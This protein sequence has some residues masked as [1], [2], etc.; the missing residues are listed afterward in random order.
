MSASTKAL[1]AS[2]DNSSPRSSRS[3]PGRLLAATLVAGLT[4]TGLA[5]TNAQSASAA[6][7]LLAQSVG[8]FLDGSAGGNPIQ[9]LVDLADARATS[10]GTQ[11]AQNPL[12]VT[13]LG[14]INL[15]L[16]GALQLPGG[17]VFHL[18]A[19][20]QV[21]VAQPNGFSFGA[22]G[23][24]NNSGG[25][26]LGGEA[27]G[28]PA[29]ATIDLSAAALGSV[30]IP[31]LPTVPGLPGTPASPL[32]ALGGISASIGAVSALAQTP[33]TGSPLP[34]GQRAATSRVA[35]VELNIGS[36]AL[37]ALL[38]QVKTL[39]NP[40]ILT[41][42]LGPIATVLGGAL[43]L[44]D[45]C[46]LN[47]SA[48]PTTISLENGAIVIDPAKAN[49]NVKLGP[50][51]QTL[52]GK[53]IS[54]LS[55]SNFDLIDFLVKNLPTILSQ[56]LENVVD[57]LITP[58]QTQFTNCSAALGPL[59]AV[60]DAL[61]AALTTGKT[62]LINAINGLATQL[63]AAGASGLTQLANGIKGIVDIG[64]NVQSGPG[65]QPHDASYP[66]TSGLKATPAQNTPVVANQTLVRALEINI[67][68][69]A[70]PVNNLAGA[71]AAA[72]GVATLA[73]GNAAAG[74]SSAAPLPATTSTS[75]VPP[76]PT[77]TNIP[78]GVPAG[79]AKPTS[80]L[81]LP[82]IL[83]I[84]GLVMASGGAVAWKLRGMHAR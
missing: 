29:N 47:P 37:G 54:N 23:A 69:A 41:G 10:P 28:F 6:A 83:L 25:V 67:L 44:P 3:G 49:I 27:G 84:V 38:T 9:A 61:L 40:A 42:L 14:S 31:G 73:L 68:S 16:S 81:D 64:L 56:G 2:P 82:L 80:P 57:S 39:L 17:G 60:T 36:P 11:S 5:V 13:L 78:T 21:A 53:D 76:G 71:A 45:S 59:G 48:L 8:R 62:T 79:F 75:T 65:T 7:P 50:L 1:E 26:S 66:F 18:G 43:N 72:G 55:T 34:A 33:K 46:Q 15:P 63:G 22:S 4:V 77:N 58:L 12:D 32:A 19:A 20:N 52:L 70:P 74:P 35:S 30:P 24:V 51:V